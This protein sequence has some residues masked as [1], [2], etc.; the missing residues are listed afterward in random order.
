[1]TTKTAEA[2]SADKPKGVDLSSAG[3]GKGQG[4]RADEEESLP[5]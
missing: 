5:H 1:M 4:K 3:G 2:V